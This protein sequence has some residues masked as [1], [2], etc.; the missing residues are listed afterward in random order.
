MTDLFEKEWLLTPER[1][2]VHV[3]TAT[4]VVADLHLG[5]AQAR[6]HSGEAVP[7]CRLADTLA[8]LREALARHR[9][10]RLII[11]G[12]LFEDGRR[13]AE[14][15]DEL[16]EWLREGGVELAGIVPGNHDRGW[17]DHAAALPWHRYGTEVDKK[18][19]V[20]HGDARLPPAPLVFGHF[21]PCLRWEGSTAPCYLTRPRRLVLPA[22]STDAAGVNVLGE[23]RWLRYRCW[24]IAGNKVLDFGC[25]ADLPKR[26]RAQT[27]R[28]RGRG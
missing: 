17:E 13:A 8:G 1:A 19:R 24:A 9:V 23:P 18:W 28:R 20:V 15:T 2:A 11:A 27:T 3:P 26:R 5:Y 25:V 4:A 6:R 22:F 12:D 10:R 7:I 14:L 21:H 16:T